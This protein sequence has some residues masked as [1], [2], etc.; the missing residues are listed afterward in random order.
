[1]SLKR[2]I[3]KTYILKEDYSN[4]LELS[5][6]F[7]NE[8]PLGNRLTISMSTSTLTIMTE[9]FISQSQE[10][11]C[12]SISSTSPAIKKLKNVLTYAPFDNFSV[13]TNIIGS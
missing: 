1:M 11:P 3:I 2:I 10:I 7:L 13:H 12:L 4:I 8:Y 9:Y 5:K 6:E